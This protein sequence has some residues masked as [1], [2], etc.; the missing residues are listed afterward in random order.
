MN[1]WHWP[2]ACTW[3][4][5]T[6]ST[7][8]PRS[9]RGKVALLFPTYPDTTWLWT[10]K[11]RFV[12]SSSI[13]VVV[14]AET[15]R[16]KRNLHLNWVMNK[17]YKYQFFINLWIFDIFVMLICWSKQI[18]LLTKFRSR[19]ERRNESAKITLWGMAEHRLKG[20][21]HERFEAGLTAK[22]PGHR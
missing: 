12:L 7:S 19:S 14:V 2:W 17:Q 1:V 22:S 20:P 11:T 9:C 13:I 21:L 18:C 5:L 4:E 6:A 3:T 15:C 10:D 16:L 8:K